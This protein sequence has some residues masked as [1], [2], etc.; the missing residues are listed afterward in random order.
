MAVDFDLLADE[1]IQHRKVQ[2][3]VLELLISL[4][5]PRPDYRVLEVGCGTGNYISAVRAATGCAC[6]GIDPSLQMLDKARQNTMGVDLR[7]GR[8][9]QM[10]F[11]DD[12]FDLVFSV[13]VIHHMQD[14]PRYFREAYRVLAPGGMICTVTESSSMI[15]SRKPF[16][17]YYPETVS[18]DLQRY[19][20]REAMKGMMDAAGFADIR[21]KSV[22][23]SF[24]YADIQDFR[25]KA[26]SCLHLISE[27]GFRRGLERM[28]QD[29]KKGPLAWISRYLILQGTKAKS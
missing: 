3:E 26:Y 19:P 10:E 4:C 29:L 8:G 17:I 22:K 7:A 25:D 2:P 14:R 24:L 23:F 6:W 15:R 12:F 18:V 27:E 11:P 9:E 28:E 21:S 20:S 16:A 5:E 1:Y 13:D